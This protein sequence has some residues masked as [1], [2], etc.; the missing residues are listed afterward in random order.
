ML[1]ILSNYLCI[2]ILIYLCCINYELFIKAAF[3]NEFIAA[4]SSWP[5]AD[6][7]Y[8]WFSK[9]Y[10]EIWKIRRNSESVWFCSTSVSLFHFILISFYT[11]YTYQ[12]VPIWPENRVLIKSKLK[13]SL[14]EINLYPKFR[15][16][17][18]ISVLRNL[19][20]VFR[21]F[22]PVKNFILIKISE[23]IA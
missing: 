12:G 18:L 3:I 4:E 6:T 17:G 20:R 10:G 9:K 15:G 11:Y 22:Y 23:K 7:S 1:R 16:S 21:N 13:K 2:R 14:V 8:C 19:R 5:K